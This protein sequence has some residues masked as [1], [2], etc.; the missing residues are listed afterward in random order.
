MS[1][2]LTS[3]ALR[4]GVHSQGHVTGNQEARGSSQAVPP[5]TV[6]GPTAVTLP[7]EVL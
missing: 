4:G 2:D 3:D 7:Q 5:G 6:R 1:E